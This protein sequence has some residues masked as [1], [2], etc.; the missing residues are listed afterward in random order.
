MTLAMVLKNSAETLPRALNGI[1]GLDY[2]KKLMKLIFVDGG[3]TDGSLGILND[4]RRR[5]AANYEDVTIMT[6]NY[7]VTEGRNLCISNSEGEMVLFVDSDVVVPRNLLSEVE[8]VFSSDPRIAFVNV[9]CVVEEERRGWVD[10]FYGS[11]GEPQG[12][13]CAAIRT[14]ALKEVGPYFVGFA[15][16]ENPN[17]L[18]HRLRKRGYKAAVAESSA[19]HIKQKPRGFYDY[20][21]YSFFVAVIYHLQEIE[22]GRKYVM[23]KYAYYTALLLSPVVLAFSVP[24]FFILFVP[25]VSYYLVRSRGNP[26]ALPALLAGMVLPIGML[27]LIL[28]RARE[29]RIR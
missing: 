1:E 24:L 17:E 28:R 20:L 29:K 2:D 3:S 5:N 7:D 13:S 10:R 9:P 21:K 15:R 22:A 18:I 26:C 6:G 27:F 19:L 8:K 4:F 12:M 23:A 14:S 11:M 25:G 16:G